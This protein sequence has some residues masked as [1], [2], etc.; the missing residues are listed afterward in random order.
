MADA[1]AITVGHTVKLNI[2]VFNEE[3]VLTF[4]MIDTAHGKADGQAR[5]SFTRNKQRFVEGKHYHMVGYADAKALEAYGVNVPPRG[6]TLITKRGYLL[7]V[8]SFTDDLAWEVQEQ[9]VDHY[10][11]G[12]MQTLPLIERAKLNPQQLDKLTRRIDSVCMSFKMSGQA[13]E[14]LRN[15]L[16][17]QFNVGNVDDILSEDYDKAMA[18]I[19]RAWQQSIE[20]LD[21]RVELEKMILEEYFGKG[22]PFTSTLRKKYKEKFQR[23]LGQNPNWQEAAA[24]LATV[25]QLAA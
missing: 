14:K 1:N 12:Q 24:K 10:F 7:L 18:V 17:F 19:E 20:M 22:I 4:D 21:Y 23:R 13:K 3:P 15:L 25:Q 11:E 2:V 6:L 9:L 16:R 8:K 5:T